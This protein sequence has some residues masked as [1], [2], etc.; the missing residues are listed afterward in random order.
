MFL[1]KAL[2]REMLLVYVLPSGGSLACG[3]ITPS[4]HMLLFVC[5][6]MCLCPNFSFL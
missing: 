5:V 1:L 3:N 4:L 6:C 2:E